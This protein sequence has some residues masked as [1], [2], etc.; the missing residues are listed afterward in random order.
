MPKTCSYCHS[1]GHFIRNCNLPIIKENSRKLKQIYN[2]IRRQN[3]TLDT[4]KQEFIVQAS[5]LLNA[6]DLN[7]VCSRYGYSLGQTSKRII[8]TA[9]WNYFVSKESSNNIP[10]AIAT[11][12]IPMIVEPIPHYAQD[13]LNTPDQ[14]LQEIEIPW[15]IDRRPSSI[16]SNVTEHIVTVVDTN[17]DF[18]PF[19]PR[20]LNAEFDQASIT[21][22]KK[23]NIIPSLSLE[24]CIECPICYEMS[25]LS[26]IVT[27]NCGHKFCS[28]CV[29][30]TFTADR[31]SSKPLSCA[32]CRTTITSM[33]TKRTDVYKM[34]SEHCNI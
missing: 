31:N 28:S 2:D 11:T 12:F 20:N 30:K 6:K 26:D 34:I 24:N 14:N 16:N 21:P 25:D 8:S 18:I 23:Y 10:T 1:E 29:K 32:L 4:G 15:V 3:Y 17:N 22:P 9:I 13:I 27:N 5:Q 33:I 7:A 19:I